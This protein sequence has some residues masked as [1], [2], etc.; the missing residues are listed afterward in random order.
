MRT[1]SLLA[2]EALHAAAERAALPAAGAPA[3]A[4]AARVESAPLRTRPRL[5]LGE[6]PESPA[7]PRQAIK[8]GGPVVLQGQ[9]GMENPAEL[10]KETPAQTESEPPPERPILDP[11]PVPEMNLPAPIP[12]LREIDE[13]PT[14]VADSVAV[15]SRESSAVEDLPD[16]KDLPSS[17]EATTPFA[18]SPEVDNR[19]PIAS[20]DSIPEKMTPLSTETAAPVDLAEK[21][22]LKITGSTKQPTSRTLIQLGSPFKPADTGLKMS[23]AELAERQSSSSERIDRPPAD[24]DTLP[25]SAPHR[26]N[27]R[28]GHADGRRAHSL[29]QAHCPSAHSPRRARKSRAPATRGKRAGNRHDTFSHSPA[30]TD[31][32]VFCIS[33]SF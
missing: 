8:L 26:E 27:S 33:H 3:P 13:A 6:Q 28:G 21:R 17:G 10:T 24:E 5:I 25:P 22:S 11:A 7:K 4:P 2:K 16:G 29:T 23:H 14:R 1:S 32:K 12:E 20:T 31:G 19:T 15:P 9:A 18:A 30:C